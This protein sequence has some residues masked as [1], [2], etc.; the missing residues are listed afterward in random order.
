MLTQTIPAYPYQQYADDD[1]IQALF[2]A[3]NAY[4]QTV[5]DWF[6]SINL[7]Y[8]PGLSGTT[9]QWVANGLYGTGKTQLA[10]PVNPALGMLNTLELNTSVLDSY[11]PSSETFYD[12]P[13]DIFKRILTWNLY[14][15]DGKRFSM[16][17]LKRRIARFL[18][19]GNGI[20]PQPWVP[21]FMV[22]A[23]TTSAIGAVVTT[24]VDGHTLT[25]SLDQSLLSLQSQ[26]ITANVLL[27]FRLAFLGGQ[28]DLPMQYTT[29]VVDIV[30]N[31]VALAVPNVLTSTGSAFSQ[32]TGSTTVSVLGGTGNYTYAWTWQTGGTG[33][34][35]DDP[36]QVATTFTAS[37]MSW[38]E[39]LTGIAL[40]TITDT[41]S[42][43]TATATCAVTITCQGPSLLLVE[44]TNQPL[45]NEGGDLSI[46]IVIEP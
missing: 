27:L 11:T 31:F 24:G 16:R 43:L 14:K 36:S 21:G 35:I 37:G 26:Q 18:F 25:V 34:T 19:G 45:L 39:T 46:P 29:L 41:V 28:L 6:N 42:S 8:Y 22:G 3:Y 7:P 1:D 44:G 33:I 17:W 2:G 13:D 30:T 38:G 4:T 10:S 40:C 15:G 12:L 5:I 23:E 32:T 9:L 20:D